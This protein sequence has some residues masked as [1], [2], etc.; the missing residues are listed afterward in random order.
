MIVRRIQQYPTQ[1]SL[2]LFKKL[3]KDEIREI[4]SFI[5]IHKNNCI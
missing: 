1:I 2:N 5:L 3:K 4:I